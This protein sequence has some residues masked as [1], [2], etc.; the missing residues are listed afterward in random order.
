MFCKLSKSI[1]PLLCLVCGYCSAGKRP[2]AGAIGNPKF[3]CWCFCKR[4][5][6]ITQHTTKAA[7]RFWKTNSG[8]RA[9]LLSSFVEFALRQRRVTD[10]YCGNTDEHFGYYHFDIDKSFVQSYTTLTKD[11]FETKMSRLVIQITK[12]KIY[13]SVPKYKT[14]E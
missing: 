4:H 3:V 5:K 9:I 14:P 11:T 8:E 12:L 10:L 2:T 6:A 1:T 7:Q 13:T